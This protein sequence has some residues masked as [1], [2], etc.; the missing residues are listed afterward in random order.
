MKPAAQTDRNSAV[1]LKTWMKSHK[2]PPARGVSSFQPQMNG[3]MESLAWWSHNLK[4]NIPVWGH[5]NLTSLWENWPFSSMIYLKSLD[6][7]QICQITRRWHSL[8]RKIS[9]LGIMIP[10]YPMCGCNMMQY[11]QKTPS[12]FMNGDI[13]I[14]YPLV[15]CYITMENHHT[16]NG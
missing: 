1:R 11:V 5:K 2:P 10:W 7:L 8:G 6:V 9:W 3:G 14:V 13:A 12:N 15:N 4:W 16:I